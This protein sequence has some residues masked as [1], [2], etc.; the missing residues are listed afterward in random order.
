MQQAPQE[1]HTTLDWNGFER[2]EGSSSARR[3]CT[4][5]GSAPWKRH[6]SLKPVESRRLRESYY[7]SRLV[8]IRPSTS[9]RTTRPPKR[10]L[11]WHVI[12]HQQLWTIPLRAGITTIEL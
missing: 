3:A 9:L 7:R 4:T 1:M 11:L 10:D 8:S 2:R 6:L 12:L 5:S